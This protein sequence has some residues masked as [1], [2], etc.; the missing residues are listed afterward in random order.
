[1]ST[2]DR[3]FGKSPFHLLQKH[4]EQ[5]E[6][7]IAKMIELLQEVE[8]GRWDNVTT[9]AN[10]ASKLEYEADQIKDD[11]RNYLPRPLFMAVDRNR[12]QDI[13]TIQDRIADRAED[14]CILLTF[15]QLNLH[16]TVVQKFAVFRDLNLQAFEEV[17]AIIGELD[18]L[19][20]SGFGGAEAEKVRH[21]SR[22][23][24]HLEHEADL[25]QREL[26]RALFE[27]ESELPY[28]D[29]Y[30]WT[31]LIRQV[32]DISNHAENLADRVRA[33]LELA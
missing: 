21:M 3:I 4:M 12:V 1:M 7:C 8:A 13:L 18:E 23:V 14:V 19:I 2:I 16:P 22:R 27:A 10:Q 20:E 32:G 33:T 31:R 25:A 30:L 6:K 9:L 5:V 17:R 29:F 24:A 26:L 28:G 15:K 11:V